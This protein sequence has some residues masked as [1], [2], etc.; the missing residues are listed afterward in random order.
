MVRR[1]YGGPEV[2]LTYRLYRMNH[3]GTFYIH[4][5]EIRCQQ[6]YQDTSQRAMLDDTCSVDVQFPQVT[7]LVYP[8][9][10]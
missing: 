5:V 9:K 10:R 6:M 7:P 2:L 4:T 8:Q 1:L 3:H